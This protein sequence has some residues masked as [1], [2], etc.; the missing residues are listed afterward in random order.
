MDPVPWW[1]VTDGKSPPI[2][3]TAVRGVDQRSRDPPLFYNRREMR[4]TLTPI[5][6]SLTSLDMRLC[7]AVVASPGLPL[8]VIRVDFGMSEISPVLR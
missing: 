7:Q 3:H 6:P 5:R 8:W 1:D 2:L 4:I